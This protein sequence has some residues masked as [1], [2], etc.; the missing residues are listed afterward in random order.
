MGFISLKVRFPRLFTISNQSLGLVGDIVHWKYKN[1]VW[2][3]RW[4]RP[5]FICELYVVDNLLF[6]LQGFT[7]SHDR[8]KWSCTH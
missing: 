6:V 2:D 5:F 1:F 4:R 7:L 3:L 8:H